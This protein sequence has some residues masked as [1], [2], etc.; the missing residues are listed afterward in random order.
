MRALDNWDLPLFRGKVVLLAGL[1]TEDR[2]RA[3]AYREAYRRNAELNAR[4]EALRDPDNDLRY[5]GEREN[6]VA[7][8]DLLRRRGWDDGDK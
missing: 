8:E 3:A 4:A 1:H 7:E 2:R 6:G 5:D